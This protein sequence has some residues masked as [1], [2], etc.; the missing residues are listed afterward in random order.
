VNRTVGEADV[1]ALPVSR[2]VDGDG[3][4]VE[5]ATGADDADGDLA[6]VGDQDTL[7]HGLSRLE[8]G[9]FRALRA[10]P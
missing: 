6:T 5:L 9:S 8:L 1:E 7:E 10:P 3:V 2:R 4:D